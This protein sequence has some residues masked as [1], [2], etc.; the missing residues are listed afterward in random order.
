MENY[1][2]AREG[3]RSHARDWID[4]TR[5]YN[6]TTPAG[7]LVFLWGLAI[8]PFITLFVLMTVVIIV[9]V[10]VSTSTD[11]ADYL[12]IVIWLFMLAW[13]VAIVAICR[14]RLMQL[15]KSQAWIWLAI[16]P[17]ANVVLF[18][19]LLLKPGPAASHQAA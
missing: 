15:G 10:S 8:Y 19:Y 12:G 7:R 6:P 18:L 17:V 3:E 14:R 16:I 5:L 2:G 4:P 13:V 1:T 11:T 9:V